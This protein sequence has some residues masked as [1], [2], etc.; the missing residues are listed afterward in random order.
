LGIHPRAEHL[1]ARC[2]TAHPDVAT[3]VV[4]ALATD[5]HDL[6]GLRRIGSLLAGA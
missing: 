2:A 4:P 1:R 6:E 5:V 3:T